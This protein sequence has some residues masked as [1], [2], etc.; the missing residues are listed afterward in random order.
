M[1][2]GQL[3][4]VVAV[5]VPLLLLLSVVTMYNRFVRQRTLVDESWGQTDFELTRRH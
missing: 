5:G 1:T 3:V 4:L 2:T